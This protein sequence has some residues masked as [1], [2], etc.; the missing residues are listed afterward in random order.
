MSR[1]TSGA[2][3]MSS[4]LKATKPYMWRRWR[5]DT[6]S[7]SAHFFTCARPGRSGDD[8]SKTQKVRDETVH[9]WVRGLQKHCGP[10]MAIISLLGRKNGPEGESE[11]SLYTF[12]GGCDTSSEPRDS[13][14]FQEWLD[15]HHKDL[16]IL[17]LEHP[18]YDYK[19]IPT[20]TLDAVKADIDEL[21]SMG[22]T[23]IVMDSGGATR[24]YMV[25]THMGA[26]EDFPSKT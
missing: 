11:F 25:A 20:E 16:D 4:N 17:V 12:C 14:I 3:S 22:R 5:V 23:V 8:K 6:P 10:N 9:R 24:T 18:T 21:T 26:K 2:D 19:G 1:G 15:C 13:L 7:G